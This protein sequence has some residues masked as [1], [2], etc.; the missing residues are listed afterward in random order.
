FNLLVQYR[1]SLL[2]R[3][4]GEW[5]TEFQV[6]QDT[7]LFSEFYQPLHD[8]GIWFGSLYGQVG[9]TTQG[10]F[11]GDARIA[12]YLA[13]TARAGVDLGR[14]FG[15]FGA[16]RAG[17]VWTQVNAR[18]ETGDPVLPTV[19]ELTAAG[20]L[21]LTLDQ[22]DHPWFPQD[23]Y[24]LNVSFYGATTAL[25]SALDYQRLQGQ[26]SF[27]KSWGS[28]TVNLFVSGGT[29]FGSEMPAYETFNLGGPLRLSGFR[30]NQFTGRDFAFGR[31]MYYNNIFPLPELLGY[32]VFA[33]AS[34][35]VGTIRNRADGLPSP[36]GTLF[37]GSVFL[38]ANTVAG[39][40]YLGAG[41]GNSGAFSVFLLLGAP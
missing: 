12:E 31:A 30:L 7:H 35:E 38:G 8:S 21:Q 41:F 24:G 40:G 18:V 26:G 34:A 36:T 20:R 17:L 39:P 33:G 5:L 32:G 10:V 37:S 2:N 29:D 14:V 23:G 27:V 1:K 6:G 28:H 9:Q 11:N 16:M 22:L 15:T 3:L 25:G 19:R 13:G 4:G